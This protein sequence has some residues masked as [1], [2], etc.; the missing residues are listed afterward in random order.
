VAGLVLEAYRLERAA[1]RALVVCRELEAYRLERV[2]CRALVVCLVL[3]AYRLERAVYPV[4]AVGRV[5][6]VYSLARAVCREPAQVVF[7]GM[8]ACR[9]ARVAYHSGPQLCREPDS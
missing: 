1:C 3:E 9:L 5:L 6:E 8:A 2:A 7:P 4:Q